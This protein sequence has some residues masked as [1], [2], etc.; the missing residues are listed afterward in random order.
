V[1]RS[2]ALE[3]LSS[4][5]QLDALMQV[6]HPQTWIALVG[7][8]VL[9][10]GIAVWGFVGS[11]PTKV[12]A[13]GVLIRPGGVFD[14][15]ASGTGSITDLLVKEG[16]LVTKNQVVARIAQPDLTSQISNAKAALAERR[17]QH[18]QL[19][20]FTSEDLGLRSSSLFMAEAK[21]TDTITFAEERL[22]A[23]QQQIENQEILLQKGLITKQAILQAQQEYFATKDLLERSRSELRQVPL[24]RLTTKTLK[25][26]DVVRS[27][28]GIN[29]AERQITQLAQQLE[30]SST[31]LSPYLG[32]ILEI[33]RNRGD[34]ISAG[35]PLLSLQLAG[36]DIEGLQV[37]IYVPPATGKNVTPTMAVEI[38]PTTAPREEF[39]FL[40]G[41]VTYV[42]EFPATPE[43]MMRVLAN[44]TL[45]Q[46]L[47]A[48]GS[49]YAVYADLVANPGSVGGYK[50]SSPKGDTLKVNSGSMCTVTITTREQRPIELVIP[51]L[52]QYTGL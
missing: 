2:V 11:I 48:Q 29:Q 5:E 34:V 33:K 30:I 20:D 10:L 28:Q 41:T 18:R 40:R 4:P 52:R 35:A 22:A 37:I 45:V 32:R 21:L 13:Q 12:Q 39:G 42:S 31:I 27:Q 19:T 38:S 26:Q 23:Q 8:L 7:M 17:S 25:D 14:V 24:E 6:A 51:I 15:F 50:W 49:P 47:S 16:D 36:S 1:Y 43:G 3:R 46:S 9:L 44:Q